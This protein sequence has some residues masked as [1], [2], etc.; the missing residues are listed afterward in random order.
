VLYTNQPLWRE[1]PPGISVRIATRSRCSLNGRLRFAGQELTIGRQLVRTPFINPFD[2]RMIPL[3]YEGVLLLLLPERHDQPLDYI[4]S[5]LWSYKLHNTDKFIPLS[6]ALGVEQGNGVLITGISRRTS[7]LNFGL[8]NYLIK[9]TM[10]S[11]YGEVDYT[12]P[13]GGGD[14]GPRLRIS[15]NDLDQQSV[16][17]DLIKNAPFETYQASVRLIASYRNSCSPAA[18]PR[19]AAAPTAAAPTASNPP[20]PR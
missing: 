15:V 1:A 20:S 5:H 8:T 6:Q 9:N 13:F 16:G 17:A 11:A 3:T 12:L 2:T 10:N 19:L 14:G 18:T 7:S 4:L